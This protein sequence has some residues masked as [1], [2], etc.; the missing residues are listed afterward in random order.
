MSFLF[1]DEGVG[2]TVVGDTLYAAG[3]FDDSLPLDSVEIYSPH[4]CS[5]WQYVASMSVCRGG[6]GAAS[7]GGR[8]WAVGGHNGSQYL[9]SVECYCPLTDKWELV[10]SMATSRAGAGVAGCLCDVELIRKAQDGQLHT[11][12]DY[13]EEQDESE[14]HNNDIHL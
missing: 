8:V 6:V 4:S 10:S 7:M 9:S 14:V 13:Q 12:V 11:P 2:V 3:G 5:A 1:H